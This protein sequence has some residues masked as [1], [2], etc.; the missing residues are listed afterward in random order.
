[1]HMGF[2]RDEVALERFFSSVSHRSSNDAYSYISTQPSGAGKTEFEAVGRLHRQNR[3]YFD[4]KGK[5]IRT[6]GLTWTY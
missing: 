4:K 6:T 1:M 2:V 5:K 3:P